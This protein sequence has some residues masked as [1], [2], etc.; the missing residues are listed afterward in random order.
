[1]VKDE[2]EEIYEGAEEEA[3]DIYSEK[4]SL[5]DEADIS[6]QEAAFM[7]GYKEA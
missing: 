1:M 4:E 6:P 7:E 3:S 2:S 5:E